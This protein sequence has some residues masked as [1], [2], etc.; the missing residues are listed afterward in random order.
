MVS[1]IIEALAWCSMLIMIGLETKIYICEFRWYVRFGVIY[2]LVGDAVI[3][4]LILPMRDYYSR[5][6]FLLFK[7]LFPRV[8][9]P[10]AFV[11]SF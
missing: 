9:F 8:C 10:F 7:K 5:L 11:F 3:L 2:V 6:V 4:N 1:L